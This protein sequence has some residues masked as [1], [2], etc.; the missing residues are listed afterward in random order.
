M[1]DLGS[2]KFVKLDVKLSARLRARLHRYN[3]EDCS[4]YYRM[5]ALRLAFPRYEDPK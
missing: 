4:L 1:H 5:M 2:T 3:F